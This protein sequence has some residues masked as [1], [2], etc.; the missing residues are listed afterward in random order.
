[1]VNND[2]SITNPNKNLQDSTKLD[3]MRDG[4]SEAD[5]LKRV[6][7]F[8]QRLKWICPIWSEIDGINWVVTSKEITTD[9]ENLSDVPDLEC[10]DGRMLEVKE[11]FGTHYLVLK[12]YQVRNA[13]KKEIDYLIIWHTKPIVK[14]C[15]ISAKELSQKLIQLPEKLRL[16]NGKGDYAIKIKDLEWN[17]FVRPIH[18]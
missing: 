6:N 1:M 7:K 17:N 18:E 4:R 11:I 14:Y 13:I 2:S 16:W 8:Q 10:E 9:Y 12:S 5:Y 15:N 3:F